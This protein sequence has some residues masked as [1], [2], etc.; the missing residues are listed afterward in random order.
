MSQGDAQRAAQVAARVTF[1]IVTALP[2]ERAAVL[3]MLDAPVPYAASGRSAGLTYDL[4]EIPALGGG[5]H[6][7]AVALAGMGNNVAA[8]RGTLLL[9]H[10][11]HVEAILMVGIAGGVPWPEKPDAH[12]RLGDVVVSDHRGVVQ[13]DFVKK[14]RRHVEHRH[15]PR[16]PCARLLEAVNHLVSDALTGQRPWE[17]HLQRAAHID[18]AARPDASTDVL[19]NTVQP[20]ESVQHPVDPQR[21][22]GMPKIFQGVIGSSGTLLK[23]ARERDRLRDKFGVRAVEMEASGIADATWNAGVGFIAIRGICDYCDGN[24][25]DLWH[26]HA[27]VAAAAYGRALLERTASMAHANAIDGNAFMDRR[28]E[29]ISILNDRAA[30]IIAQVGKHYRYATPRKYL[31]EFKSL[32][33]RH[34]ECLTRGELVR[35]HETLR[36]IHEL[37]SRLESDEFWTR[38]RRETPHVCYSLNVDAFDHGPIARTY[39]GAAQRHFGSV[40][41]FLRGD[42]AIDRGHRDAIYAD[43]FNQGKERGGRRR[44]K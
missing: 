13:F 2:E 38:H 27:A 29:L 20:G 37:S 33:E 39:F 4:G 35:A 7:V 24:K 25:N 21:R 34:I 30:R 26:V 3:A 1:G 41:F 14:T 19:A 43:L 12:V 40:P 8:T 11:P 16:P 31:E 44:T 28:G 32:H 10:F 15:P 5:K 36:E 22:E 18:G 17:A 23:D 42:A 9:Q 6:V